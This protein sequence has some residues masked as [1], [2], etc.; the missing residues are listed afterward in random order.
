MTDFLQQLINGLLIGGLY[1]LVAL[2]ISVVFGLTR[3]VNFAH[4]EIVMLGGFV[5]YSLTQERGV[6]FL[7]SLAITLA[8]GAALGILADR[9]A[10]RFTRGE[11][12]NGLVISL[13]L[14]MILQSVAA[15]I[16]GTE[17]L[18]MDVVY[19]GAVRFLGLSL[20]VQKVVTFGATALLIAGFGIFLSWTRAGRALRALS[21]EQEAAIYMGIPVEKYIAISMAIGTALAAGAGA[22]FAALFSMT[23]FVGT[24]LTAKG[25]IAVTLGGLGSAPG[26][27]IGGL[28]LGVVE[29]MGAGYVNAAFTDAYGLLLFILVLMV[30]PAGLFGV[31]ARVK[32]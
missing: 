26:T 5:A 21:Q 2:G 18:T 27:I 8:F 6:P 23:P 32:L 3:M 4:G 24:S 28:M 13:G 22:M 30:R 19:P 29:A 14:I 16:W 1:A 7:L 12:M 20:S 11:P 15:T 10:F 17:P 9:S 25:F 31:T